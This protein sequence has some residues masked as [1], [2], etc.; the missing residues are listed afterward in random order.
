MLPRVGLF[1]NNLEDYD[2]A[3]Y[4]KIKKLFKN[5]ISAAKSRMRKAEFLEKLIRERDEAL[6]RI[7]E[8][9]KEL[10]EL[11]KKINYNSFY[12]IFLNN[13]MYYE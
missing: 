6:E 9:E 3:N 5:R 2:E 4:Q 7:V 11:K 13:N 12:I 10:E 1:S 8:L